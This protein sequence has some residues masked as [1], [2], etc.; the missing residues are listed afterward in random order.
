MSFDEPIARVRSGAS[1]PG[2]AGDS[3]RIEEAAAPR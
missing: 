1:P 3:H 2:G